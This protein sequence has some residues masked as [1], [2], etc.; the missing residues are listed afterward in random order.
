MP[1]LHSIH[2]NS[3]LLAFISMLCICRPSKPMQ[4]S[5]GKSIDALKM[6][7]QSVN[8]TPPPSPTPTPTCA[9]SCLVWP[10]VTSAV[11]DASVSLRATAPSDTPVIS[12]EVCFYLVHTF[13][14]THTHE[15]ARTSTHTDTPAPVVCQPPSVVSIT[16]HFVCFV[17]FSTKTPR[18]FKCLLAGRN[19]TLLHIIFGVFYLKFFLVFFCRMTNWLFNRCP[20]CWL[21]L[22]TG[23]ASHF[24]FCLIHFCFFYNCSSTFTFQ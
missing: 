10:Q 21:T 18:S 23:R 12:A 3:M 1:C 5:D 8:P 2:C 22:S 19:A 11:S 16:L 4:W 6:S 13:L 17:F 14:N 9:A 20:I 15:R 7:H 24:S